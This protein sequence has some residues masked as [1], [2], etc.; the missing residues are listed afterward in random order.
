MLKSISIV[1]LVLS[2]M[3]CGTVTETDGTVQRPTTQTNGSGSTTIPDSPMTATVTDAN[4]PFGFSGALVL[5]EDYA[6]S[7]ITIGG[8]GQSRVGANYS[9]FRF[10]FP[11]TLAQ[12]QTLMNGGVVPSPDAASSSRYAY[13]T[14]PLHGPTHQTGPHEAQGGE[15]TRPVQSLQLVLNQNYTVDIT[16][17][18]GPVAHTLGMPTVP[19]AQSATLHLQGAFRVGCSFVTE[20]TPPSTVFVMDDSNFSSSFCRSNGTRTGLI[21]LGRGMGQNIP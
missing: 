13:V 7:E 2:A 9:D 15:I 12:A 11:L 5:R 14:Y 20:R 16:M 18:L 8:S 1:F 4:G 3:G 17:E 21:G 10:S 6:G 19:T